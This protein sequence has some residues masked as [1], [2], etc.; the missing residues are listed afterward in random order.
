MKSMEHSP[1]CLADQFDYTTTTGQQADPHLRTAKYYVMAGGILPGHGEHKDCV[2]GS[3]ADIMTSTPPAG[4][5]VDYATESRDRMRRVGA[6]SGAVPVGV[7]RIH[8]HVYE[9]PQFP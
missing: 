8:Y 3:T 6:N 2:V 9:S 5:D 4:Y 1:D 7:P